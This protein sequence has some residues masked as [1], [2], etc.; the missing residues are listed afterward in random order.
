MARRLAALL[1]AVTSLA[2]VGTAQA[3]VRDLG[4][5]PDYGL[6]TDGDRYVAVFGAGGVAVRDL[7]TGR[8]T[9][10]PIPP[11]CRPTA[12]G[13]G[14]LLFD[15]EALFVP[16]TGPPTPEQLDPIFASGRTVDLVTGVVRELP[17]LPRSQFGSMVDNVT[18]AGIGR[19]WLTLEI[20]SYHGAQEEYRRRT[21]GEVFP[22]SQSEFDATSLP[23]LDRPALVRHLCSP[24]HRLSEPDPAFPI[25]RRFGALALAGSL[26]AGLD[27][28][29]DDGSGRPAKILLEGCGRTIRVVRSCTQGGCGQV[30]LDGHAI[31]WVE[32]RGYEACEIRVRALRAGR[33][34]GAAHVV[35]RPGSCLLAFVDHR[36]FATADGRLLE[37]ST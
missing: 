22:R 21:T 15:C 17:A 18:Y 25:N 10:R 32:G 7:V 23:D 11:K 35:T 2:M 5:A 36:L 9:V 8:R 20:A 24:V 6:L 37:L 30:V 29:P 3:S 19:E 14:Q 13:G 34:R 28:G 26:A 27:Y 4:P 31:A 12:I 33:P 1:I 16:Y